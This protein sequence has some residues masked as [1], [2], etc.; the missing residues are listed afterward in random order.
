MSSTMTCTPTLPPQVDILVLLSEGP[1]CSLPAY[2]TGLA[3]R[4]YAYMLSA[5]CRVG[6]RGKSPMVMLVCIVLLYKAC[7]AVQASQV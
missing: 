5:S 4:M 6:C 1:I 2:M 3:K 7:N